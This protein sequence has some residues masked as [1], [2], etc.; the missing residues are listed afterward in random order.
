ML[1]VEKFASL[2]KVIT[3]EEDMP[4]DWGLLTWLIDKGLP[5]LKPLVGKSALARDDWVPR[6]NHCFRGE[7]EVYGPYRHEPLIKINGRF[8]LTP[9]QENFAEN[10]KK[11]I[12]AENKSNDPHAILSSD[13]KWMDDPL[14]FNAL[15]LDFAAVRTL[16]NR[17]YNDDPYPPVLSANAL[18]IC[19]QTREIVLHR[20]SDDSDT[21]HNALHTIGGAY[22]P[23]DFGGREGDHFR[24]RRTAV[25]EAGEES[26]AVFIIGKQHPMVVLRE[27]KT[28]FVQLAFLGVDIPPDEIRNLRPSREGSICLVSYDD[29]PNL[30][31]HEKDWNPTGKAAIL[32]W[33]ALGAPNGGWNSQFGN[34]KPAKLFLQEVCATG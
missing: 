18:L 25:R 31:R 15:S 6:L 34:I 28:G 10:Q 19:K 27:I 14:I 30:L 4:L 22:W 33:L 16:R 13:P 7:A 17:E 23:P 9:Q 21:Y 8:P 2:P 24:L 3:V 12:A 5:H 32:A 20:R 29:L 11:L 1:S 26:D